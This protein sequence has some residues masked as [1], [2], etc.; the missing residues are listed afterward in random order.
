MHVFTHAGEF[1][2]SVDIVDMHGCSATLYKQIMVEELPVPEFTYDVDLC[3]SIF[4]F[5]DLSYANG[6]EIVTRTWDFGDGTPPVVLSGTGNGDVIHE[7]EE[8][9][10]YEV[11]LQLEGSNGCFNSI[12]QEVVYEACLLPGFAVLGDL[13]CQFAEVI[14]SD[15]SSVT[16]LID[17]WYWDFGDGTDTLYHIPA[18]SIIHIYREAGEFQV[19]LGISALIN[20]TLFTDTLSKYIA[21]R[22]GPQN[23]FFAADVCAGSSMHFADSTE[24]VNAYTVSWHWN[25]GTGLSGDTSSLP[26]PNFLYENYGEYDV[27]LMTVNNW[28]CWDT[29]TK[30]VH[31]R[32]SPEANFEYT[33]GCLDEMVYFTDL[34]TAEEDDEV[35]AWRWNFG[36]GNTEKDTSILQDPAY[37]Y[38]YLGEKQVELIVKNT[39]GCTDTLKQWVSIHPTPTAG[40][41]IIPNYEQEQGNI[42]LEDY[43]MG[44]ES[45]Y[46]D[47][48]DGFSVYDD[49]PPVI[50]RY[51]EDGVYPIQQIVWN[52]FGCPDTLVK[53]Y[54][55]LFKTLFIPN[56][57]NPNGIDPEIRLFTPKGRNLRF[58]HIA[59]YNSW[60]ELMWESDKLDAE[61]RPVES[62][63]GTYKGKLVP[64]DVYI[65][66]AEAVFKDGTFWEGEVP[67]HNNNLSESTSGYVVVVR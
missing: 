67:G 39:I 14:F 1:T 61:G 15:S 7:F 10:T 21:V 9:G 37:R 6:F 3:D 23:D 22:P 19:R 50:H 59:I 25:F 63:D 49:Y 54:N 46:W 35:T 13:S 36:D 47:F 51:E 44:A 52:E 43:S 64:T 8:Y 2:V 58:F 11:S 66:K 57:L 40:F 12:S 27:S 33:T 41:S 34:S 20:G 45:Y 30:D 29:I 38:D 32:I 4:Q 31:V 24:N 17:E 5:T 28:G 60:G 55:F 26:S 65:W 62:W 53:D 18:D 42:A 56:A 48:G 16:E